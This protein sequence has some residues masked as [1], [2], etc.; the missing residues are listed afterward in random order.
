MKWLL[1]IDIIL[2]EEKEGSDEAIQVTNVH[3][4]EWIVKAVM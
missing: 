1:G 2:G 4:F 3:Y